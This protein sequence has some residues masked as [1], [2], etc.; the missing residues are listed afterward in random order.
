MVAASGGYLLDSES[1]LQNPMER[2][3]ENKQADPSTANAPEN[4][5]L[6]APSVQRRNAAPSSP[7]GDKQELQVRRV[8]V[9]GEYFPSTVTVVKDRPVRILFDRR[10]DAKCSSE[11]VLEEFGIRKALAPFA[12]TA[13]NFTPKKAGSFRITCGMEMMEMT[14]VVT[15]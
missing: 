9:E 10:E 13:V 6:D 11:I 14:L 4:S 2:M 5:E 15:P 7:A 8:R 1:S 3:Q 12:T